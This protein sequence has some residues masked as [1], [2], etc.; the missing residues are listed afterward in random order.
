MS[1]DKLTNEL[2]KA[3]EDTGRGSHATHI[4]TTNAPGDYQ[5]K[6][7]ETPKG[8]TEYI[9]NLVNAKW[10]KKQLNK[11]THS[12]EIPRGRSSWARDVRL[13]RKIV[14]LDLFFRFDRRELDSVSDILHWLVV[15]ED[16]PFLND[17]RRYWFMDSQYTYTGTNS[18]TL[19]RKLQLRLSQWGFS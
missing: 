9:I 19:E 7:R 17:L 5:L 2:D 4:T 8:T 10:E 3:F 1:H 18:A 14:L 16:V 6:D 15:E 11:Q 13:I 12:I